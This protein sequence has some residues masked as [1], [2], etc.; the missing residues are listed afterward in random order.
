MSKIPKILV[1]DHTPFVGGAQL[2]V[3]E[4]IK[5]IR[6]TD[7]EI[8]IVNSLKAAE[9]GFVSEYEKAELKYYL[10]PFLP[11]KKQAFFGL[12]NLLADL[13]R[14]IRIIRTKKIDLIFTNTVRADILGAL[15]SLLTGR[16][17]IWY[18]LDYTFPR[19]LFKILSALVFKI[20]FV[21]RSVAEYYGMGDK[22]NDQVFYLWSN[23]LEKLETIN[24]E[25]RG[26]KR[27]E[28]GINPGDFLLIYVGR[29]VEHKGPQVLIETI[30]EFKKQALPVKALVIGTGKGQEGDNELALIQAVKDNNLEN[31]IIFLGPQK[32]VAP[33]LVLAD[34]LVLTTIGP[35]PFSS[36]V[37]EAM[38][39]RISV[40]AT[41]TGGTNEI[42]NPDKACLII[43]P[44]N[45]QALEA[46]IKELRGNPDL[47]KKLI[48]RAYIR[49]K[50]ENSVTAAAQKWT[51]I[52]LAVSNKK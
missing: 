22:N 5:K 11:W 2:A 26:E 6:K 17:I 46:A 19:K 8:V 36:V 9:L 44:N 27:R 33:Y 12:F 34:A 51:E 24:V 41:N 20:Y 23:M 18:L 49:A 37:L 48:E 10:I 47:K 52:F 30:K 1:L 35:E 43:E 15:A 39:S 25:G 50:E 14:L 42:N 31:D 16:K 28:L 32:E 7:I 45:P 40:I 3:I 38:L 4:L 21:S 29:L 13:K